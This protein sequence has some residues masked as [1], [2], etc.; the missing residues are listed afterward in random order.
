MYGTP[1]YRSSFIRVCPP[2]CPHNVVDA[3][4]CRLVC[5]FVV[6]QF[7][8]RFVTQSLL[9]SPRCSYERGHTLV[10]L[11]MKRVRKV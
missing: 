8:L 5:V 9:C 6:E 10:E 3:G 4:G 1:T 2:P 11:Y 7:A